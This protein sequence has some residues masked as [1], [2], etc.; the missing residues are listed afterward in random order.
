MNDSAM[1]RLRM[2]RREF[3]ARSGR[4]GAGAVLAAGLE[5]LAPLDREAAARALGAARE[6]RIEAREVAWE[7]APGKVVKAM[8]Y[9]GRLP[10]PEIRVKEG[11]RV[12]IVLK[13]ALAEPTT[14]HWHGV[15]VPNAMDGVPGLTQKPVPPGEAFV[16]EFEARPAGTR[17][18][19]THFEE[20]RQMDLGLVAPFIIEPAGSEPFPFDRDHTLVLD[21]WATGTGPALPPTREGTAGAEGRMGGMMGGM[22]G[23]MGGRGGGMMGRGGMGG[24]MG[25][26]AHGPAYDIMTING[27]AYPAT[28]PLRVRKGER[29]RLRLINASADHTHVIRLAGHPLRVTHTDGNPLMEAVDVDAVPIAPSERY[30]VLV[31]ADR[32]GA[33]LLYCAEPGHAA[34]G[35][36]VL[37]VYDG[38]VGQRPEPPR[39]GVTGLRVWRYAMGAGRDVLPPAPGPSRAF[40]QTLSGGMMGSDIWTIN[41]KRYPDTDPI[42]ARRGERVHVRLRNMS[43]E[44]HPMH[45]HGQS[46]EVLAVNGRRLDLPLVKD[47]VDVEAHMGSVEIAFTAHNPGDWFFHCHK[48][49]HMEGGMIALVKIAG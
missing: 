40:T 3:L 32:P 43:M 30:D 45:L 13:N 38:H 11:E 16:Y 18:Y 12:R 9:N 19:H 46:F 23:M 44:A 39:E 15:D 5:P 31:S 28:E 27:K 22:G 47:S 36:Q 49:M 48:P 20:H 29:V 25:G 37:V 24:M 2:G 7:L 21:D 17:W 42:A 34:A 26:G 35:E 41:G 10:G 4:I 6:F 8:A 1:T 33:W 14:I